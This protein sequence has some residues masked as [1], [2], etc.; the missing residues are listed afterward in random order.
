M[1]APSYIRNVSRTLNNPG[2]QGINIQKVDFPCPVFTTKIP[3]YQRINQEL[4][5]YIERHRH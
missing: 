2:K 4:K 1:N 5:E 3:D